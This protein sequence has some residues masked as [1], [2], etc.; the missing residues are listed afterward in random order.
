MKNTVIG[1]A[2]GLSVVA[3]IAL[4]QKDIKLPVEMEDP[5]QL[6]ALETVQVHSKASL[7]HLGSIDSF[8]ITEGGKRAARSLQAAVEDKDVDFARRA[9]AA[10]EKLIP[11]ENFGGEYTAL[12]WF[13][14]YLIADEPQRQQMLSDPFNA[15]YY[16]M[17]ADNDY[18]VLKEYI[19]RKYRIERIKDADPEVGQE[20]TAFL[21]DFIL[22]NNPKREQWEQTSKIVASLKI[23]K[24]EQI[25]DIGCG[26]GYYT[27]KFASL[28]GPSGRVYAADINDAHLKYLQDLN[29]KLNVQN[30]QIVTSRIDNICMTNPVDMVFMCSVY[31]IVY[32]TDIEQV[33]DRFVGSIRDVLK[34][35]GR[36]VIVDNALVED[37][38]L[39]YHGPFIAKELI[40]TQLKHYG[41]KVVGYYQYIPQRYVLVFKKDETFVAPPA[42]K[43]TALPPP[44]PKG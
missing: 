28:V 14:E 7:L 31:H 19:N 18:A 13:S 24:G 42:P 43:Q 20:R 11:D 3:G 6:K 15:S 4:A 1:L 40:V 30:I 21:E 44:P 16:H 27:H 10:Y 23:K 37:Q 41:F 9:R 36:L 33:K 29:Q 5:A 12:Q 38:T 34:K 22:F 35:D 32:A 2:A 8:D 25:A 39:P 26:P 17:F